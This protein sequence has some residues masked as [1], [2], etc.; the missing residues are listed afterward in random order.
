MP[1]EYGPFTQLGVEKVVEKKKKW[2][3][4]RINI[5][6]LSL[7]IPRPNPRIGDQESKS[8]KREEEAEKKES[9]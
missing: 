1:K 9:I 2:I 8:N 3:K 6:Q 5:P 4:R 7:S